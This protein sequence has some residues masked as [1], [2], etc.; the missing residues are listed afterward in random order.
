[1]CFIAIARNDARD[2][3]VVESVKKA[4][5]EMANDTTKVKPS[6]P[7]DI[8]KTKYQRMKEYL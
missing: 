6:K 5:I 3:K 2:E 4:V 7:I 1:M 8:P